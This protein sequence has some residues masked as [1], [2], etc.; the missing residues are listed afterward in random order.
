[1]GVLGLWG[2]KWCSGLRVWV[3]QG[4]QWEGSRVCMALGGPGV[5]LKSK[6]SMG[7]IGWWGWG[8][9]RMWDVWMSR[10]LRGTVL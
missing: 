2:S 4:M 5:F 9:Q 10:G 1:M 8:V 3:V 6:I 7:S